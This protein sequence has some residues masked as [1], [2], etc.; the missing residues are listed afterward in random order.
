MSGINKPNKSSIKF[1]AAVILTVLIAV[2]FSLYI[3][4]DKTN[5][6]TASQIAVEEQIMAA[7]IKNMP[8]FINPNDYQCEVIK[9]DVGYGIKIFYSSADGKFYQ[10]AWCGLAATGLIDHLEKNDLKTDRQIVFFNFVFMDDS[11]YTF[12]AAYFNVSERNARISLQKGFMV[13][14]C[15]NYDQYLN[16]KNTLSHKQATRNDPTSYI[17]TLNE[18]DTWVL[19]PKTDADKNR[20]STSTMM[21]YEHEYWSQ[22]FIMENIQLTNDILTI[23]FKNTSDEIFLTGS[24]EC[25]FLNSTG[26]VIAKSSAEINDLQSGAACVLELRNSSTEQASDFRITQISIMPSLSRSFYVTLK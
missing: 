7:V 12:A 6:D 5:K 20:N 25:E 2:I 9:T 26:R 18:D 4:A 24:V 16:E 8:D 21:Q 15:K 17:M 1:C 22:Y 13:F 19:L 11:D 10:S 23:T 3:F 14:D